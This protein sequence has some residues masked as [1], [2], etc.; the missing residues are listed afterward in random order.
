MNH[1]VEHATNVDTGHCTTAHAEA[2]EA[3]RELVHDDKHPVAP[4]HDRLAA[5]QVHAPQ[6]VS[7]VADKRQPRGPGSARSGAIMFRQHAGHDVPVDVDPEC[8]R[9]DARNPWTAE[10]RIARLEFDDG[11]D[12]RFARPLRSGLFRTLSR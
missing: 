5:T 2:N 10:P 11:A 9:N 12:E 3:S 1:G 4:K 8:L 6:A 7:G